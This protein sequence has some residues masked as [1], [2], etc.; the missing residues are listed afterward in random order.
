V[1]PASFF[2]RVR[3]AAQRFHACATVAGER[4]FE[5]AADIG[6]AR[7]AEFVEGRRAQELRAGASPAACRRG[8]V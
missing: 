4:L 7:T 6:I 5:P 2:F 1:Q 3:S 8:R